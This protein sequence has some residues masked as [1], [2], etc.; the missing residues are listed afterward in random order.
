MLLLRKIVF[1]IF[2]LIYLILCPLIV[3]RMLGFVI[4][5]Q[6]FHIIK[7]GLVYVSTNPP[8][9]SVYIDGRLARQ[10]T[11][12][13]L[14]DLP[15]GEHFIR[16]ELN[17]YNDWERNIPIVAKKATVLANILLIPE[18]WPVKRISQQAYQNIIIAGE[19]I[20][21]ATNPILKNIDIFHTTQ[22]LAENFDEEN[23]YEKKPLFS[24]NSIY[25]NG[26]LVRLYNEPK[27]PFILLEANIKDK[28][29][30][31]WINL[32]ENPPLIEDVS[33]FF[34]EIPTRI[35]W[36]NSNND[37]IFAFMSPNV[38]RINIKDKA[39]YPQDA[40]HLPESLNQPPPQEEFLINDKNDLLV[41]EG[42]QIRIYPK[43]DFGKP[44]VYD[45]AK[46]EPSTNMHFE[47]K[48]GELFYLDNDTRFLF[49][50]QI[51]P[52][53]PILNIPIPESLRIKIYKEV[54]G[55]KT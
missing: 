37:N 9:A 25:A 8:D 21:I 33:D 39:I 10:K 12:A 18:E 7:T 46:S 1:Y 31:L 52:Y 47:E 30:F 2:S 49:A 53:H 34:P 27:S 5:P 32:K 20:L 42:N 3:A 35:V 26:E 48:N 22:G 6:T 51:L 14:K 17:D 44:R 38:Y 36:D 41:R 29:K 28:H 54:P 13:V 23:A 16:I 11:P 45:I 24:A 40:A 19:D 43:E 15:P 4:N 55:K 50:A